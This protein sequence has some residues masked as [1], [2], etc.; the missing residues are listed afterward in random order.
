[1]VLSACPLPDLISNLKGHS[2]NMKTNGG[3]G[4]FLA[5]TKSDLRSTMLLTSKGS[6]PSFESS[7]GRFVV[8]LNPP[9][10][11]D[12]AIEKF[13]Q[14][15]SEFQIEDYRWAV[16]GSR[17]DALV[18]YLKEEK[19]FGKK[20]ISVY[21]ENIVFSVLA[22]LPPDLTVLG[23]ASEKHAILDV[24]KDF[25]SLPLLKTNTSNICLQALREAL[26]VAKVAAKSYTENRRDTGKENRVESPHKRSKT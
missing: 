25:S 18:L 2:E 17:G 26:P 13:I 8:A 21:G 20:E 19:P 15:Q 10:F 6:R 3:A 24:E 23:K 11:H 14:N 5:V 9:N 22:S 16:C 7:S 4:V 12:S 1:M